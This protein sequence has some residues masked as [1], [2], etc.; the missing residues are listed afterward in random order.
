MKTTI[1]FH[2]YNE[3]FV[4]F[5]KQKKHSLNPALFPARSQT[6][7]SEIQCF[8]LSVFCLSTKHTHTKYTQKMRH[9]AFAYCISP[10]SLFV[11]IFYPILHVMS[12]Q[13]H[14]PCLRPSS[15]CLTIRPSWSHK[16][17]S[18]E[19]SGDLDGQ[20]PKHKCCV[21]E[22]RNVLVW[23]CVAGC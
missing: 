18:G 21:I 4:K 9:I 15:L 2:F 1:L 19:R 8:G 12:F 5:T 13:G 10:S 11:R 16:C 3:F 17:L 22:A 6:Q 20:F 23:H 14:S 7:G